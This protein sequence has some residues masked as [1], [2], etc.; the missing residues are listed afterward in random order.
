MTPTEEMVRVAAR[1][2]APELWADHDNMTPTER[3]VWEAGLTAKKFIA[4]EK[5]KVALSAALAAMWQP[6]ETAPKDGRDVLLWYPL[7][8]LSDTFER[9]LPAHWAHENWVFQGRAFRGYSQAYQPTHWMPLPPAPTLLSTRM[10][11]E[12]T[13][14]GWIA[15]N[16]GSATKSEI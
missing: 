7:E 3:A 13:S 10:G 4:E 9:V 8:G 15:M 12:K 5:A 14:E 1:A 2:L 6:I 11:S 16:E